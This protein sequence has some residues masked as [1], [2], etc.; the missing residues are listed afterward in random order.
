M[1]C[2]PA[3]IASRGSTPHQL[4]SFSLWWDG[5]DWLR[6][7]PD[8][9]PAKTDWKR[10]DSL[11]ETKPA[12]LIT[13]PPTEDVTIA[14]SDYNHFTLHHCMVLHNCRVRQDRRTLKPG[15][16]LRELMRAEVA[17]LKLSQC[18]HFRTELEA[19]KETAEVSRKSSLIHLRPYLDSDGLMRVGGRLGKADITATQKHPVILHRVDNLSKLLCKNVHQSDL[20][21]GPTTLLSLLC[22]RYRIIGVKQL[23][24]DMSQKCVTC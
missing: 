11:P 4:M 23:V 17:L 10:K 2:N 8:A 22:L 13:S 20:H 14:F 9:W 16:S 21:V 7:P 24:K 1:Q 3:D 5:P 19:L 6:D 15:L 12:I 18:R